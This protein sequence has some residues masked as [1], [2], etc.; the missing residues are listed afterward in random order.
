MSG[1]L[2]AEQLRSFFDQD[3]RPY[4]EGHRVQVSGGQ[5]QPPVVVYVGGQPGAGKSRANERA[6]QE[7]PSLVPVIGDDLRQFRSEERR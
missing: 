4:L 5:S 1:E 7:R 3:V 2:S 6:T